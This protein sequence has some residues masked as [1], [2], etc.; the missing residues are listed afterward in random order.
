MKFH[1]M[2]FPQNLIATYD[3][4]AKYGACLH[5]DYSARLTQL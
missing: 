4:P 5:I 2:I 1:L 3:D